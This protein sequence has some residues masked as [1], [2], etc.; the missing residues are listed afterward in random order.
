ML[1]KND[2]K[3]WIC[4]APPPDGRFKRLHVDHD[5]STGQVRGLLCPKCN[6]T[7]G[8]IEVHPDIGNVFDYLTSFKPGGA[9]T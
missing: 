6:W 3:C 4:G 2:G 1:N 9:K 5:H 8:F 7:V